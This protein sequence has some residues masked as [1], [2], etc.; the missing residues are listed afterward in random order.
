[1]FH[2]SITFGFIWFYGISTIVAYSMLNPT[3]TYI[4]NIYDLYIQ[5]VDTFLNEPELILLYTVKWFQ[6]FYIKHEYFY[7][8]V[9]ICCTLLKDF[10]YCYDLFAHVQMNIHI[11]F[12][13]E[14]FV[15]N[16]IFKW[17]ITNLFANKYCYFLYTVKWFQLLLSYSCSI[18]H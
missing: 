18:K 12:V 14:W 6:V 13:R 4:L 10:N 8:V 17:V 1:M 16:F 2:L 3:F 9:V 7:F 5:L 15:G 11:K